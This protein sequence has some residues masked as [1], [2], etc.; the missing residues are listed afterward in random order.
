MGLRRGEGISANVCP[1]K[2]LCKSSL[3]LAS[4]IL[5][6]L[7]RSVD[8]GATTSAAVHAAEKYP[9]SL[10]M[11]LV[12]GPVL[13]SSMQYAASSPNLA[14]GKGSAFM[15]PLR[16]RSADGSSLGSPD[17]AKVAQ[18]SKLRQL[19]APVDRAASLCAPGPESFW[20]AVEEKGHRGGQN[21]GSVHHQL[22]NGDLW[23]P[24]GKGQLLLRP[25]SPNTILR[26]LS[27]EVLS[28]TLSQS[29][30]PSPPRPRSAFNSPPSED[31]GFG[32]GAAAQPPQHQQPPTHLP[33]SRHGSD[34]SSLFRRSHSYSNDER[35]P[36]APAGAFS[37]SKHHQSV[38]DLASLAAH[39]HQS[40]ARA[41]VKEPYGHARESS[42]HFASSSGGEDRER[43][44]YGGHPA[45]RPGW[46]SP[47]G[48]DSIV[49]LI[50]SGTEILYALG[51]GAR[52]AGVTDLCDF[53]KEATAHVKV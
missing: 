40:A 43:S 18:I 11:A 14:G 37:H 8:V 10:H 7:F 53:P 12:T 3:H 36:P 31:Y 46:R 44:S 28:D 6:L 47:T 16:S 51:L 4:Y 23:E 22:C 45:Y 32:G 49:S 34:T 5:S 50:Q 13:Q 48:A 2:D 41:F 9:P 30:P 25:P 42:N 26:A 17:S 27:N 1:I 29:P 21:G 38:R 15:G 19:L 52:I 20:E 39:H 35:P 24:P 33:A